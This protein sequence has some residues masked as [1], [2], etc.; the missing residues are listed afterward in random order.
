L[1]FVDS[2]VFV[3]H[4]AADPKYGGTVA[5]IL[6]RI[7]QGEEAATST[8]VINQVVSY[9]KWKKA[10]TS[11]PQFLE[12]LQSLPSLTKAETSFTDFVEAKKRSGQKWN[13]FDDVLIA[14]QMERLNI[15]EIYSND[16]DFDRIEHI[17]RVFE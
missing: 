4:M 15:E 7:E 10:T 2:N 3:Y 14:C 13:M 11:I 12:F 5:R 9:L 8:L 6:S 17:K 1:R 16:S